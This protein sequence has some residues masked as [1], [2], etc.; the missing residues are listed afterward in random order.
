MNTVI[1]KQNDEN[2][3]TEAAEILKN[4][5]IV[6]IPTETVYGLAANALDEEAVKKIFTAKGRPQDNPLI[7]HISSFDEIYPLVK[8]V[9]ESAKALAE[10]FWPGPLTIILPKSDI[11]PDAVCAGLDTV[12]VRMPS[13]PIAN[14]IIKAAGVPLAAPSANSSGLPSPTNVNHVI[15]DM[16]GKI[17]AIV[18]GGECDV[19]VESTVITLA[20][21]TPRLLRPGGVTLE[22]LR[23]TLG[24][25]EVDPAVTESL[26]E[27]AVAA[28]PG[29]KYKHYAPKAQVFIIKSTLPSFR[30]YTDY[31][32][33]RGDY[34][35]CFDG[36][37][38]KIKIPCISY[39]SEKN[40]SAQAHRLF[41][42]LRRA[43]KIGAKRVFVRC[44]S[45]KGVGLAVYN[46]LIRAAAFRIIE[47][48][49]IWGITG[50]TGAGK[51]LVSQ[52]LAEKGVYVID[53]DVT[54]RKV[55]E[56]GSPVLDSLA[57]AFGKD[58]ILPDGTLN[59]K[60]L[61]QKAFGSEEGEKLLNS[62]THPAITKLVRDEIISN[63][64]NYRLFAV[65]AALLFES[66]I[67]DYCTK[68]I[69]VTA[70]ESIRLKRIMK[71][72]GISQAEA[73][74]RIN[75]QKSAEYYISKAD[76]VIKNNGGEID[77]AGLL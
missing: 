37:E 41:A 24:E 1:Y 57:E 49:E 3:I 39:G 76:A 45:L 74:L 54:A 36:E 25:V 23:E 67:Y 21:E 10:K 58:I 55:A 20:T 18:D 51:T 75:A 38:E 65:D 46:R 64:D 34:A 16:M 52:A 70:D 48:P 35:V 6:A 27:N 19:G 77:L 14:R 62:I 4:G 2:G 66:E 7:V 60:A 9:P 53:C 56:K 63:K 43:D 8:D 47:L 61:A 44:P 28:S 30:C 12:A 73:Q 29:M 69:V 50:Q 22:E 59:R 40:A 72:D 11:I 32:K 31:I 17:D 33:Q 15:D 68:T 13:H 71:R 42:I 5:G 26:S